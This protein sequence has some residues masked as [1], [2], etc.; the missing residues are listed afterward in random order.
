MREIIKHAVYVQAVGSNWDR[1]LEK[2]GAAYLGDW[3]AVPPE[4]D[5]N[6]GLPGWFFTPC[7]DVFF[8]NI[9]LYDD[10]TAQW[11]GGMGV[12]WTCPHKHTEITRVKLGALLDAWADDNL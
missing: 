6:W 4:Q 12:V 1:A 3:P 9:E 5:G 10:G 11:T 7:E 2:P 8:L